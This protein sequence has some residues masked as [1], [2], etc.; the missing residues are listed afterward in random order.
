MPA[1]EVSGL[2]SDHAGK[3]RLVAHPQQQAR[4]DDGEAGREHHRVEFGDSGKIDAKIL[5]GW[6]ADRADQVAQIARKVGIID[7]QV[8]AGNL[9]LDP[10]HLVPKPDLIALGGFVPRPD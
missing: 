9:L 1:Q 2:V 6:A 3:L 7:Q 4:E 10:L 5:R 8:R